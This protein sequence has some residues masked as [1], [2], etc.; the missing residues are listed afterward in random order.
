MFLEVDFIIF[1]ESHVFVGFSPG[2]DLD[3]YMTNSFVV[4]VYLE[5]IV[6][7]PQCQL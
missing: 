6:L 7:T 5:V 3:V 1:N 2:G 4:P